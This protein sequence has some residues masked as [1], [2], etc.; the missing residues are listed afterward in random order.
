MLTEDEKSKIEEAVKGY[1]R[2]RAG[3]VDAMRV[4][5]ERRGW[6][7]DEEIGEIALMLGMTADE[8]DGVATFYPFIFRRPVGRHVIFVCDGVSCWVM[9]YES[10][11][12]ALQKG[13]GIGPGGTTDDGRFTLLP[14]SCIGQCERAPA[15]MVDSEVYGELVPEEIP[16]ILDMYP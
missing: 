3:C 13:L 16:K 4:V 12:E 14:V 11:M 8:L 1:P 7:G 5:Q 15:I 2:K 9:G 10:I 6:I